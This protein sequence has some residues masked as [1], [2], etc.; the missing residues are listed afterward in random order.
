MTNRTDQATYFEMLAELLDL[1]DGL[2]EWELKFVDDLSRK[3]RHP[4]FV[5]TP[6]QAEKLAEIYKDRT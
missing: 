1:E 2:S 3:S 5:F 6:L 4:G